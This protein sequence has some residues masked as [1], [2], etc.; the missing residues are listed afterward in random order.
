MTTTIRVLC[1]TL[2]V[3]AC[4]GM[5]L[6]AQES[7][8]RTTGQVL[9]LGNQRV[10]EGDIRLEGKQYVIRRSTGEVTLPATTSMRLFANWDEAYAHM[11]AQSNLHDPDERLRLARWCHLNGLREPA[12]VN[13]K[14]ALQLRPN[15]AES[16]RFLSMVERNAPGASGDATHVPQPQP[17]PSVDLSAEAQAQFNTRIQPILMNVCANC[18]AAGRSGE[19]TLLRCSDATLNRRTAQTNL[20]AVLAQ[21]DFAQPMSSPLLVKALSAHGAANQAPLP[22]RQAKPFQYLQ[23]WVQ[24]VVTTNP[25]LRKHAAPR[26]TPFESTWKEAT[27]RVKL[28]ALGPGQAAVK[29]LLPIPPPSK[30]ITHFGVALTPRAIEPPANTAAVPLPKD[31]YDPLIFNRQM[32]PNR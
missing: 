29:P 17:M 20:A 2:A 16:Q 32:H 9:I 7:A 18:H 21:I 31:A 12:L 25:H 30:E 26:A 11:A 28:P 27:P 3:C 5:V 15:H 1:W 24:T 8:A 10:L 19:F 6:R 22:N 14:A 4:A 23:E 13:A